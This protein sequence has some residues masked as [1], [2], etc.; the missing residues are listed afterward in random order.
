VILTSKFYGIANLVMNMF[1][2]YAA[3]SLK[4]SEEAL[5][6]CYNSNGRSYSKTPPGL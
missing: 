5:G 6:Y 2:Y 3:L 4:V 1:K